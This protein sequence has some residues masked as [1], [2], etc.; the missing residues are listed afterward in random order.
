MRNNSR[1]ET[2]KKNYIQKYQ[3]LIGE[4]Q[5]LKAGQHPRFRLAKDFYAFHG[6]CAQTFL[7][8]YGRYRHSGDSQALLPGKR[9]PKWKTRRTCP[10]IETQVLALRQRG[11]SRYEIHSILKPTLKDRTPSPS[12]IYQILKRNGQQRLSR[13]MM[14]EKRRVIRLKAGELGHIDCHHLSL[15]LIVSQPKRRYLVCLID[16]FSRLAWAECVEDLTSLTVMFASLRCFNHLSERYRVRFA[17]VLTDNGPEFGPK[18]S[19]VKDQHPFERLLIEL[20]IKHRYTRPY[21]PQ[22][23]GKVERFWRTLNEDLIEGT[24]LESQQHFEDEL[25]AYLLYYNHE[26]PHQGINALKPV[27]MIENLSTN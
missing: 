2:L 4:Y 26:R 11:I 14:E 15:D 21:R 1:D 6:T 16:S 9:G 8:Y 20:G 10:D 18:E 23:N 19:R 13:G 17:E 5:Q 27:Q 24:Y 7:K 3:F 22:T 12:G 25:M